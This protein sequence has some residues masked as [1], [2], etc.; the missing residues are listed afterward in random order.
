MVLVLYPANFKI[1]LKSINKVFNIGDTFNIS[2]PGALNFYAKVIDNQFGGS[3]LYYVFIDT[4]VISYLNNIKSDWFNARNYK[5]SV[6]DPINLINGRNAILGTTFSAD[7]YSNQFVK[8]IY[9]SQQ[10]VIS[11]DNKLVD[12]NWYGVVINIGN[13]WGQYNVSIWQQSNDPNDKLQ[14][15][16]SN[17]IN[18]VVENIEID[19]YYL[20]KST[21]Y[22]TSIRL[23]TNTMKVE[24]QEDE[25]LT[26]F[27]VNA[28]KALI[29]DNADI[30]FTG[31][32]IAKAR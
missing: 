12:N 23:F 22:Q 9:G 28:D 18:L 1:Q 21:A 13:S 24:K 2:R 8:I 25:L 4:D 19:N 3:G 10:K 15:V 5:M 27:S 17:T 11:L 29:L 14:M 16:E 20:N 30:L 7:I 32:Y 26:Y 31:P 6:K